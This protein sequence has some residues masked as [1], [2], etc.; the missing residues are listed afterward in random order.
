VHVEENSID[1]LF[2][3]GDHSYD[4]V[5]RD[6]HK[7]KDYIK[8]GGHLIFHDIFDAPNAGGVKVR[9]EGVHKLYEEM[10]VDRDCQFK[11][12]TH[13]GSMGHYIKKWK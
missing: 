8:A 6:Y 12:W 11:F 9:A 3:D 1:L 2:I 7:W 10:R 5:S 13:V 4:G